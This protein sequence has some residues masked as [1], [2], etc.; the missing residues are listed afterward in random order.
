ME[1]IQPMFTVLECIILAPTMLVLA[2]I[3]KGEW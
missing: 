2:I 3:V 1:M